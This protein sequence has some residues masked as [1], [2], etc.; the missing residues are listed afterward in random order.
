MERFLCFLRFAWLLLREDRDIPP[1]RGG[2][3]MLMVACGVNRERVIPPSSIAVTVSM[4][5]RIFIDS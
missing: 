3:G 1:T 5:N 2:G 4:P